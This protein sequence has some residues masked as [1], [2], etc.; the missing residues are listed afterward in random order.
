MFNNTFTMKN[1]YRY[2]ALHSA[3]VACLMAVMGTASLAF[4]DNWNPVI[5]EQA[6]R[7]IYSNTRTEWKDFVGEYCSDGSAVV[8]GW[9][10]TFP[11]TWKVKGDDQVC[12]T[13]AEGTECY[14][15]EQSTTSANLYRA[16]L[17][18]GERVEFA[19]S[20]IKPR[21]CKQ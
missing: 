11:R 15:F 9:G 10:E 7:K 4:A 16:I 6:L 1:L 8:Y 12:V 21:S 14:R 2:M 19:I 5:G 3:L 17:E 13:S 18:T 20:Y